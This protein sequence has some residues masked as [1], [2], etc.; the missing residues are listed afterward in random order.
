MAFRYHD[1]SPPRHAPDR[2]LTVLLWAFEI[3]VERQPSSRGSYHR[4][5]IA[6]IR[7][8]HLHRFCSHVFI[9]VSVPNA[10]FSPLPV[11]RLL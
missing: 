6:G 8:L 11:T 9:R 1:G 10:G 7:L 5:H 3:L 2:A 4:Y